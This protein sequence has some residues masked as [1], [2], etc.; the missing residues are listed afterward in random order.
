LFE[1][2]DIARQRLPQMAYNFVAG[3][4]GDELT[5][6]RNRASFDA[7]RLNRASWLT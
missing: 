1:Y 5:L 7:I 3:A 4:A 6:R 2:E